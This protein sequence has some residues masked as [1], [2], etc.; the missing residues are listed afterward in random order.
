MEVDHKVELQVTPPG[1]EG[2]WDSFSN[3]EL[4]DEDSNRR[5]GSQLRANIAVE[6]RRLALITGDPT[7]LVRPLIF[8]EVIADEGTSGERWKE[9]D[10]TLG[11][12]IDSF[13][14]LNCSS[15]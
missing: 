1:E 14:E 6:R 2:I 15:E 7:W 12:Q 11:H 13:D 8:D 9:D 5:C 4:L 3:Y 10:I